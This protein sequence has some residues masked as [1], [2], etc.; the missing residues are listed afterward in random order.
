[1]LFEHFG[2]PQKVSWDHA[3]SHRRARSEARMD[4]GSRKIPEIIKFC[5]LKDFIIFTILQN[6]GT[7]MI[8]EN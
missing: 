8:F 1:M 2:F 4:V 5:N 3:Q 7:F 6:F